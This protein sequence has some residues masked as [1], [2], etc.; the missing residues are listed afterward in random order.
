MIFGQFYGGV[1]IFGEFGP[2]AANRTGTLDFITEPGET[3]IYR[4]KVASEFEPHIFVS[5]SIVGIF[6]HIL[7]YV[8]KTTG[9]GSKHTP[10]CLR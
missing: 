1:Q 6:W 5:K 2:K 8:E 4:C 9:N 3:Y 7:T 10:T